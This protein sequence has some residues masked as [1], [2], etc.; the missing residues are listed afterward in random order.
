[1]TAENLHE[2]AKGDTPDNVE[3]P[4]DWRALLLWAV[5]RF[6]VGI[7]VAVVF[8]YFLATVYRDMRADRADLMNAYKE[9]VGVMQQVSSQIEANT[10]AI[11]NLREDHRYQSDR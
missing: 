8:G 5:G 7:L 3:I 10:R 4:K 6:G 2:V 11:E 1:M 9:A